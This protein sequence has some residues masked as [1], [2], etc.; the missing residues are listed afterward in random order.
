MFEARLHSVRRIALPLLLAAC[1]AGFA[2]QARAVEP[3]LAAR[4]DRF[5]VLYNTSA[6]LDVLTNDVFDMARLSPGVLRISDS[7]AQATLRVNDAGT[8]GTAADDFIRFIPYSYA[9]GNQSFAYEFCDSGG[10]CVEGLVS[11]VVRPF[12]DMHIQS[13]TGAGHLDINL[14]TPKPADGELSKD[15]ELSYWPMSLVAPVTADR[16]LAVDTT[17]HLPWDLDG[18]GTSWL[19][20]ELFVTTEGFS[21]EFHV[22]AEAFSLEGGDADLYLGVDTDGDGR[23]DANELRCTAAMSAVRERCEMQINHPG[24]GAFRVWAMAHNRSPKAHTA[25]LELY[26]VKNELTDGSLQVTG[27]RR[28]QAGDDLPTRVA[29]VKHA[30]LPGEKRLGYFWMRAYPLAHGIVPVMMERTS[31]DAAPL[32]LKN[33]AWTK[34]RLAPGAAQD[35]LFIDV[36]VG[37]KFLT[38]ETRS[39]QDVNLYLT[40]VDA[41]ASSRI[42]AAP[43]AAAPLASAAPRRGDEFLMVQSG[44]L[45]AGRWQVTVVNAGDTPATLDVLPAVVAESPM[46][47][48]GSYFNPQRSGH[49]LFMYPAGNYWAGLWYTYLQDGTP[50]W[51]Y[52]QGIKPN[53]DGVWTGELYRSGWTVRDEAMH[54]KIGQ[55]QVTPIGGDRFTFTYLLDGETGSEVMTALGRGCPSMDGQPLSVSAHWFDPVRSGSGYSVQMFPNY[56]F[57][58]AFIYD[59]YGVARFLVAERNGFGGADATLALEQLAGFCPLCDRT[60]NPA[61]YSAGTLRRSIAAGSIDTMTLSANFTSGLFGRWNW[62]DNVSVL[63]GSSATQG[64]AQ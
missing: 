1:C 16:A 2:N 59:R 48:P 54:V 26:P 41:P 11:I 22:L 29:W 15:V 58:A 20:Q 40:K 10:Q 35:K 63:G 31:T 52:L 43:A 57:H 62:Q 23:P 3:V 46:I 64:C 32:A 51:Y 39:E 38:V 42:S 9:I 7:T 25:R 60:G 37:A 6:N 55:A 47:R 61:R 5:V 14:P 30:T 28:V 4:D 24:D 13:A 56:E 17:P 33:G 12:A 19:L 50:T 49:G 27:R 45:T 21:Q 18:L 44:Q 53:A 8:P 34:L 36:P